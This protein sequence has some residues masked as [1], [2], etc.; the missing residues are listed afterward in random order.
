MHEFLTKIIK[1]E[2]GQ[3]CVACSSFGTD[4]CHMF[5]Q[6]CS[7]CVDCSVLTLMIQK[8]SDYER[9]VAEFGIKNYHNLTTTTYDAQGHAQACCSFLGTEKCR[10]HSEDACPR[11]A[12]IM[13][14][15]HV[16]EEMEDGD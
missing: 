7:G 9:V 8:L 2:C 1:N 10:L 6:L 13:N 16:F 3:E 5:T 15:L 12:A 11:I 14:Q 4:K